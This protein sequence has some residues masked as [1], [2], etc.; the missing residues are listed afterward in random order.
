MKFVEN[1]MYLY[2]ALTKL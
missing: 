2:A 1:Y